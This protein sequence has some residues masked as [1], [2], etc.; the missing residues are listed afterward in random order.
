[1][2]WLWITITK[3]NLKGSQT[4]CWDLIPSRKLVFNNAIHIWQPKIEID[5][6]N[7]AYES[8][9]FV[10][11]KEMDALVSMVFRS[12]EVEEDKALHNSWNKWRHHE[13]QSIE[14]SFGR[15]YSMI[16]F[17][18]SCNVLMIMDNVY[19]G[20][21]NNECCVSVVYCNIPIVIL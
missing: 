4:T 16:F 3:Y 17:S 1:M 18:H 20:V 13:F 2:A 21:M 9:M 10:Y 6:E 8:P 12:M 5:L 7:K 15:N 19:F 14:V 11:N